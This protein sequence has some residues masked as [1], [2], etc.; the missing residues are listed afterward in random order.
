MSTTGERLKC[1]VWNRWAITLD[2]RTGVE[3]VLWRRKVIRV[4]C[5]A[6]IARILAE[7]ALGNCQPQNWSGSPPKSKRAPPVR[8]CSKPSTAWK[9]R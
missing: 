3:N 9:T 1:T 2:D 8:H 5:T 7:F 4:T 6:S